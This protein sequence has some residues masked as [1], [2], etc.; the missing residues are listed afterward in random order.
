MATLLRIIVLKV[1]LRYDNGTILITGNVHIPFTSLDP[2]THSLRAEG[3]DYQN[4]IEYLKRSNIEYDDNKV[5]DLI[6]SPNISIDETNS[7]H[8]SL[9]DYQK[10]ALDSWSKAG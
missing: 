4:I 1:A 9:R 10:E 6:P 7:Q 3:L 8:I 5:L 2:R